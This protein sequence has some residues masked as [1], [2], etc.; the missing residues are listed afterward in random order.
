MRLFDM[1]L[2]TCFSM[3]G[4]YCVLLL[5]VVAG[6]DVVGGGGCGGRDLESD[7]ENQTSDV[8]ASGVG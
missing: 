2:S 1:E 6:F 8:S 5:V 7:V 3:K 4:F